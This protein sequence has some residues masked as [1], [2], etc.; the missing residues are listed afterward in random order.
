[1]WWYELLCHV[2]SKTSLEGLG[3]GGRVLTK[4]ADQSLTP[5]VFRASASLYSEG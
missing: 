5:T 1:M 4:E 2:L 3:P